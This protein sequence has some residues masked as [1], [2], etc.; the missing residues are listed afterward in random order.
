MQHAGKKASAGT[1][2][3]DESTDK[4]IRLKYD[5]WI[6]YNLRVDFPEDMNDLNGW[7]YSVS[8]VYDEKKPI[9]EEQIKAAHEKVD[10]IVSDIENFL[11]TETPGKNKGCAGIFLLM[12][13]L[14]IILIQYCCP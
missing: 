4:F 5:D 10:I 11:A 8:A 14:F 1:T 3:Y 12:I 13:V 2:N 9:F 6:W 7:K